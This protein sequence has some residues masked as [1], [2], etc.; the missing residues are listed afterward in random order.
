[1]TR[2]LD[3]IAAAEQPRRDFIRYLLTSYK[4][5]D[6]HL[7]YRL[8]QQLEEP[9]SIWQHPYL[10]GS[11]PYRSGSSIQQ[12]IDEQTL[13][14][15]MA[16]L[17]TPSERPLYEHQELAV[18][19]IVS[20]DK[21]IIVATGTGSGKT[22]CFLIPMVDM[23]LKEGLNLVTPGVRVLLLYPMNA[24]VND[25]VKRLRQLLCR[26]TETQITFGYYTSRTEKENTK[27]EQALK[28]EL[29]AYE[30]QE[31]LNLLPPAQQ[32]RSF[33]Q[34]EDLVEAAVQR[35]REVQI[36]SR[37]QMWQS[38][39]HILVT[40]YSMLEHMLIR[41]KEREKIFEASKEHFKFLVVDEAHSYNG[42]TGSEVSMLLKRF[43]AAM[44]IEQPGKVRCIAT[45][46]SL[47]DKSVDEK[48]LQ[49]AREFFGES[50]S[51]VIRGNKVKA[52]ERLGDPYTLPQEL[53]PEDIFEFL[54]VFNLPTPDD[55]EGWKR[56]LSYLVPE[57]NLQDNEAQSEPH[58]FIWAT[59]KQHPLIHR[60]VNILAQSPQ[61]WHQIAC[62]SDLWGFE[63]PTDLEGN[64]FP[65]VKYQ[66]QKALSRLLQIG[67]LARRDSNDLPLVPVRLHLL[68][69]SLE[70]VHVCINPQCS[71]QQR[72][73]EFPEL[74]PRYGR[75]YLSER[76]TCEDC[77]APVLELS[78]CRKCGQAYCLTR[79]DSDS[80]AS[81]LGILPRSVKALEGN[82]YIHMLTSGPLD[83]ETDDE[84]IEEVDDSEDVPSRKMMIFEQQ[85]DIWY[86]FPQPVDFVIPPDM[87]A[88]QHFQL[89]LHSSEEGRNL[90]R[91]PACG[92]GQAETSPIRRF[93]SYT[94]APLEVMI[95]SL[96]ELLPDPNS[97]KNPVNS[98][99]RKILTFSDGRQDAAFFASDFQR[100]H[101][102]ALYRQIVWQ[103]F[104]EISSNGEATVKQMEERL[105]KKFLEIS[106]P[107][108][109][110]SSD[111]HH[112]SYVPKDE[113]EIT[114]KNKKDCQE[115]AQKRA[116]ELLLREFGLPSARRFSL[117]SMGLLACH[118]IDFDERLIEF[119]A[120]KFK[121]TQPEAHIFLIGLTDVMRQAGIVDIQG[122][123]RYFPETYGVDGG[124]PGML[125][126][127]G[128]SKVYLKLKKDKEET[129]A[130]SFLWRPNKFGKPF[131]QQNRIVHY[132]LHFL[133]ETPN[134]KDLI[135]LHDMLIKEKHF[136][137]H[138]KGGHQLNWQL[139]SIYKTEN[140]WYE[141]ASCKQ[142]SHIPGLGAIYDT[143]SPG[144][145]C[146]SA[147]KCNGS[148]KPLILSRAALIEEPDHYKYL[149]KERQVLPLRSQEHTAQLGVNELEQRENRFRR[150]QI[151]LLSCSTTL[152]MGVDIGELQAVALRNF[153]PHVSNYQQRAGRA[154]R[155]TDGVA[156]TLMY[157]QRR[158]HDRFYF[159]QPALL[160]AGKNQI[161]QL[162]AKNLQ[163]QQRHIR[164]ELLGEYL[165]VQPQA[166]GAESITLANFLGLNFENNKPNCY[167]PSPTHMLASFIEWLQ[168]PPAQESI[169]KW[170][171]R[172]ESTNSPAAVTSNFIERLIVFETEQAADWNTLTESLNEI[173]SVIN[174]IEERVKRKR[175]EAKRDRL[176]NELEKISK[177]KL[178]DELAQASILPIYG[179][180]IDV[181][182]LLTKESDSFKS[183]QGK[184]RLER[185]RRMALGEYAPGQ[186]I[187]VDDR[188]HTSVGL[189][190]P[191]S[192]EAKFYWVCK[193][194]NYFANS[195]EGKEF[196]ECPICKAEPATSSEKQTRAYRI[197]KS[198]TTDWDKPPQVT[199]YEKPL[200][201]PISQ[202]FLA[203]PGENSRSIDEPQC[204]SLEYSQGGK[205]FLAN[206]GPLAEGRGF[207]N[208][209]FKICGSCGRDL[210]ERVREQRVREQQHKG[211]KDKLT[212]LHPITGRECNGRYIPIHL[213]HEFLS[214]LVKIRF[215]SE[216]QIPLLFN[217]VIHYADGREV[218]SVQGQ[219]TPE[220]GLCFWRSLTSALLAASAQVIDVPRAELDGLFSPLEQGLAEVVIYDNVPG[221]A[222]YS[223]RIAEQF[224]DIL[225][226]TY[227]LVSS[228]ACGRSC[229]DC[230]RTYSNQF[231]HD[232]LNRH[233]VAEFL[234]PLV[235]QVRP[236][237]ALQSFAPNASRISQLQMA[238]SMPA[239][240]RQA[241]P[242]SI[243]YIPELTNRLDESTPLIWIN[244][245]SEAIYALHLEPLNLIVSSLPE[246][247]GNT[248]DLFLRKRLYQWID[249]GVLKLYQSSLKEQPTLCISSKHNHH[250]VALKLHKTLDSFEW[251]QTRSEAGVN[252]VYSALETLKAG[253]KSI[254]SNKLYD[255][256]TRLI[257]PKT[258]WKGLDVDTLRTKLGLTQI[259]KGSNVKTINYYDR[260]LVKKGG[261]LLARLLA[262]EWLSSST[263]IYIQMLEGRNMTASQQKRD[264]TQS[265]GILE[266]QVKTID[267]KV[268]TQSNIKHFQH[269]RKLEIL[270]ED[271]KKFTIIFDKGMDFVTLQ[272]TNS[273]DISENTYVVIDF[274]ETKKS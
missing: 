19:A 62:S 230:L 235:E 117:E 122:A 184:H 175:L 188:V 250:R 51:K 137:S 268:Q 209:G 151:N 239:Y 88:K 157:G 10:E 199:S 46:A 47:G 49:F 108:P 95:D 129:S 136:S 28:E 78:S 41:P 16:G 269:Q 156:V 154:G 261:D 186:D 242:A 163:I 21:N 193:A 159:E 35:I 133:E 104:E 74:T 211:K 116:R 181:V 79:T 215:P 110:R 44:G 6:P 196:A 18:R 233:V 165:R 121:L 75:L 231:F 256:N 265:F 91:C 225:Q 139:S 111:L 132:Y 73:P 1:M 80:K 48:V 72:S 183:T 150:G 153:P 203:Q 229:Y 177:R 263:T 219:G 218:S 14:P 210:S 82:Q 7:R 27:A 134:E 131:V 208:Q 185:D 9:G 32:G 236:D 241:S 145:K 112:L 100:T 228:C 53:T 246:E 164:A 109:D 29:A 52:L 191:S 254:T 84:T 273:Y 253:A 216:T 107:H 245:L 43:K 217:A 5:R 197:P 189:L 143:C 96:F 71:G 182:R 123:S 274:V 148:L 37:E 55:L 262:G 147:Y 63:L 57:K 214:D 77:Q 259:L 4:L 149:I 115:L 243:F 26:Q 266:K 93:V 67:T 3:P 258:T 2:Y 33:H 56:E 257:Q 195:Q 267:I 94:D 11:Q 68:F 119:V 174:E 50:F 161:P 60:L 17:F 270:N 114:S 179:F 90:S 226:R 168:S 249:Q 24:L 222:G 124:R 220:A 45:S 54:S 155:R 59:L 172:L 176:E 166:I 244:I 207:K 146:C 247:S 20:E 138:A 34:H 264:L 187:V 200:R 13:H 22:E 135:S 128:R 101:T 69:R 102:E 206:Q 42:A 198:F 272:S 271:G 167:T 202:V 98:T 86:G 255:P 238:N 170:L 169:I 248:S 40:N 234:L 83:S 251:L 103:V 85:K 89:H 178:H 141:C 25:Q 227:E 92:A 97:S 120:K 87:A 240:I 237:E 180:P 171:K 8:K 105:V 252:Y 113:N 201:Q 76:V 158:P 23:L 221:G 144:V 173:Y 204:Y 125:D 61:P 205:F 58:K 31:L 15:Y 212:H 152:E 70:G 30:R 118:I 162:D 99:Q 213:G 36:L 232:Q 126:D 190:R 12:L 81:P 160:I 192:L 64:I 260:Y 65:S 142:L 66:A 130:S 194:C 223:K 224:K 127:N 38:P 106:I 140:D 39:P